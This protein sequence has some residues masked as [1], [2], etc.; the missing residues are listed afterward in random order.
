MLK[1]NCF[2]LVQRF[3]YVTE[4]GNVAI[5]AFGNKIK[6]IFSDKVDYCGTQS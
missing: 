4:I 6:K 5:T 3:Y 1:K 2:E